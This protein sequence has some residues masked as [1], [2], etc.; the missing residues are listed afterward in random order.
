MGAV[1]GADRCYPP[2]AAGTL[3]HTP[4]SS[5]G[6][7]IDEG[8]AAGVVKARARSEDADGCHIGVFA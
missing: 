7:A 8:C 5:V 3:G 1:N 4:T 6:G 2:K